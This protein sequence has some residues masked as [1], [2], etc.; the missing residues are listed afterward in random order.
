MQ[1]ARDRARMRAHARPCAR[2][3]AHWT[4]PELCGEALAAR[5]GRLGKARLGSAGRLGSDR[6]ARLGGN[7][8]SA[9]MIGGGDAY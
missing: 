5:I 8:A 7:S 2:I 6:P 3:H 1:Y 4:N 9:A